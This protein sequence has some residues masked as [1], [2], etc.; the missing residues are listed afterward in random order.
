METR[1]YGEYIDYKLVV[2]YNIINDYYYY[3]E[4]NK[5]RK[6]LKNM[7]CETLYCNWSKQGSNIFI[8]E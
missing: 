8:E 3:E 2:I 1:K 6:I 4:N 7:S 5:T